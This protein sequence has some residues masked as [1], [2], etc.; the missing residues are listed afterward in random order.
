MDELK[1]AREKINEIDEQMAKLFAERMQAVKEVAAYKKAHGLPVLD[2]AR[3]EEL[4]RKNT[5][6]VENPELKEY[7]AQFLKNNTAVSRAYQERLLSGMKVAYCG[8]KGAFAYL[9]AARAYPTA[10]KLSFPDF[11]SAYKAVEKGEAD[12][13]VLPVENSYNGE[14]GQ[15]TDLAFT[16]SLSI[17]NMIELPITQDL[18]GVKG[19]SVKEIKEVWSHPQAIGQ[20]AEYIREKGMTAHEFSNT[21][22]AAKF[23][24]E[25]GDK[26]HAAIGSAEAAGIF[27]LEVL[28]RNINQSPVNTTR[29]AVFARAQAERDEKDKRVCSVFTFTVKNEAGALAKAVEIIGSNGFN[30]RTIRSRPMKELMWQYYFY[31]EAE[32]NIFSRKG[33]EMMKQLSEHCDRLKA[34]GSFI[35]D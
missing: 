24:A 14:V 18:L 27:G 2:K 7:Y 25:K 19:A 15:V 31:V 1:K 32:G 11:L 4:L 6:K 28:E 17:V 29:F 10:E 26:A 9:S 8:E 22:L 34:I 21:A 3:E 30:M 5:E 35:M 13:C 12:A 23:V 20:C 33:E 16:G